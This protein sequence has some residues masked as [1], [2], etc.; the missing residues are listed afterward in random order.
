M[1]KL[2]GGVSSAHPDQ[3]D[4]FPRTLQEAFGPHCSNHIESEL[5]DPTWVWRDLIGGLA[6]FV[7]LAFFA[8]IVASR[9]IL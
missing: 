8:G 9:C 3:R 6:L 2:F 1:N 5:L 7:V 4:K